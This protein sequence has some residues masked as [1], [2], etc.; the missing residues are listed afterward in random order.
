[1]KLR[2]SFIV[3]ISFSIHVALTNHTFIGDG[4]LSL[5]TTDKAFTWKCFGSLTCSAKNGYIIIAGKKSRYSQLLLTPQDSKYILFNAQKY[6]DS[7]LISVIG[8][9]LQVVPVKPN[10]RFHGDLQINK[11]QA[12]KSIPIKVLLHSY[13]RGKHDSSIRIDFG[14]DNGFIIEYKGKRAIIKNSLLLLELRNDKFIL[15][16][17]IL[18]DGLYSIKTVSGLLTIDGKKYKGSIVLK[19]EN[20]L[21]QIVNIV[22][23]EDYV[24]AVVASESWPG[25]SLDINKV[26]AI[27]CRSYAIAM[28]MRAQP[29]A[30]YHIKSSNIHQQYNLYGTYDNKIVKQAINETRGVCLVYN[31][32]PALTMYD[33]CCGGVVPSNIANFDFRKT[34]YLARNY[35]CC[36]CKNSSLYRWKAIFT[37]AEF[38]QLLH[39]KEIECHAISHIAIKVKDKAGVVHTVSV[40]DRKKEVVISGK[41]VYGLAKNIKSFVFSI[42]SKRNHIEI[43]GYG[44]G[45]HIGLCQWGA[46]EMIKQGWAFDRVLL[47]YYPSTSLKRLVLKL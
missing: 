43:H 47:F 12:S 13:H 46:Y 18:K 30:F 22:D 32:L 9:D 23:L 28:M 45:H 3:S 31:D 35:S 41:K 44:Y 5:Q 1:M 34:P 37:K 33:S 21:M 29:S 25:W 8:N 39:A 4:T 17:H 16:K 11:S 2:Y 40:K 15:D 14:S 36:F 42:I 19:I 7:L 38:L 20:Q 26:L 24:Y 27:S 6:T 10:D